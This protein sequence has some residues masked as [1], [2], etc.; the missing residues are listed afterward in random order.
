[1]RILIVDDTRAARRMLARALAGL[2]DAQVWEAASRQEA[3]QLFASCPL[4]VALIDLRLS[5]DPGNRDGLILVE[6]ARKRSIVPLVVSGFAEMHDVRAAM[7]VGAHDYLLK[8]D[9]SE[10]LVLPVLESIRS[11][12]Q[13]ERELIQLRS[14]QV[15]DSMQATIIGTSVPMQRLREQLQ[16]VALSQ[17]P[18]L[19][20]GPTGAGKEMAVNAIH[21]LGQAPGA[22]LLDLNCGAFPESL[23]ESQLFGHER[24]A[25]TGAERRQEGFC[26]AVGNGTLFLDEI[27]ELPLDLQAKLLRVLES[28]TFRPIGATA[29]KKFEGRI[30]TATHVDLAAAV[31]AGTFRADLYYRLNVLEVRVPALRDRIEDIPALVAH[32][33][34][35]QPHPLVFTADAIA[36]LQSWPWPGNVRE[37]RNLIDRLGVFAPGGPITVA[38]IDEIAGSRRT[39]ERPSALAALARE[40]LRGPEPDKLM[41]AETAL[42]AEALR[43]S[44][45]NK[46]GAARLLGVHRKQVERRV[47]RLRGLAVE[48]DDLVEAS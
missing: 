41:A 11:Q 25:F 37:L 10:E 22:P 24:G 15:Q 2:P 1:M 4:D 32:F 18:V 31:A 40:V 16:R 9:L 17:R 20:S 23:I 28:G 21:R 46:A 38:T 29:A 27:A 33:N 30:V 42:I 45:G 3:L 44:D 34:A 48:A 26:S 35:A 13:L 6:E 12:R 14:Q 19:V 5:D 47:G 39:D 8:D 43:L 7:R 36:Y